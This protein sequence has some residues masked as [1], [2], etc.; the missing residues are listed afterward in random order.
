M[1]TNSIRDV[2]SVYQG[3]SGITGF[4]VNFI[5][6]VVLQKT[7][8]SGIGVADQVQIATNGVVTGKS[9]V[10]SSLKVGDIVKYPVAG[11]A[12]D[13]FNRIESVG[14]T[15]AKVEAVTVVSGVCEGGLPSAAVQTNI[16]VGSP[17]VSENGG[18]FAPV[19]SSNVSTVNLGSSNLLVSKQVTG[20]STNSVTGALSIPISN[21]S[22]GLTSALFETFDAERYY[23][24]LMV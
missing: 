13:S 3:T 16:V 6:D 14:V 21:A 4:A 7:S 18:L 2:K 19:G 5:G 24:M 1:K 9:T 20:Q 17:V 11:Q 12:V 15:T 10:I 22:I 23:V 8:V